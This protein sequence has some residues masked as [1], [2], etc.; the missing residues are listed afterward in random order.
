MEN[1]GKIVSY[2]EQI[3]EINLIIS[4]L[5]SVSFSEEHSHIVRKLSETVAFL[6]EEK[7][8]IRGKRLI[9][10]L[11]LRPYKKVELKLKI[12]DFLRQFDYD[13]EEFG[14]RQNFEKWLWEGVYATIT[15]NI[16]SENCTIE[17]LNQNLRN[18]VQEVSDDI[19]S[20]VS[21]KLEHSFL[22]VM[23]SAIMIEKNDFYFNE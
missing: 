7:E 23:E 10:E 13:I 4:V 16:A 18:F 14:N 5:K 1:I 3:V 17:S 19:D 22:S 20:R 21:R 9:E 6:E 8:V 2:T 12:S 15:Y 11:G